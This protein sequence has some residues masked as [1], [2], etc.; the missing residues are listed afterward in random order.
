MHPRNMK[1]STYLQETSVSFIER[2]HNI[3]IFI[4]TQL[5]HFPPHL[6]LL[7]LL[8]LMQANSV[9]P[10]STNEFP[11]VI[12]NASRNQHFL[13][14]PN[15]ASIPPAALTTPLRGQLAQRA[16]N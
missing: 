14:D 9:L 2:R 12:I 16:C 4:L 3:Y 15:D 11:Q 13:T 6:F 8:L 10:Q 1:W 7:P 5:P